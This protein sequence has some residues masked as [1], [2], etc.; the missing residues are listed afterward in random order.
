MLASQPGS[1]TVT[2]DIVKKLVD[3]GSAASQDDVEA[4]KTADEVADTAAKVDSK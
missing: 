2:A 4:A 1:P 3:E